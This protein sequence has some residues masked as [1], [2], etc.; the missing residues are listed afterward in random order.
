MAFILNFG[1]EN[2]RVFNDKTSIPLAP[3]T[4]LTGKNNSGKSSVI[5]AILMLQDSFKNPETTIDSHLDPILNILR[6]VSGNYFLSSFNKLLPHGQINNESI[7]ISFSLFIRGFPYLFNVTL[8]FTKRP[9]SFQNSNEG[10]LTGIRISLKSELVIEFVWAGSESRV[11]F[12]GI[13][14]RVNKKLTTKGDN[15]LKINPLFFDKLFSVNFDKYKKTLQYSINSANRLYIREAIQDYKKDP[16]RSY[17][18]SPSGFKAFEQNIGNWMDI[19]LWD[20]ESFCKIQ[21]SWLKMR[22]EENQLVNFLSEGIK[23]NSLDAISFVDCLSRLQSITMDLEDKVP[24]I[25]F[26]K[27]ILI[28]PFITALSKFGRSLDGFSYYS[29]NNSHLTGNFSKNNPSGFSQIIKDLD[30]NKLNKIEQNF[31]KEAF[32]LF[33]IADGVE[34]RKM[35]DLVSDVIFKKNSQEYTF[36]DMGFGSHQLIQ[37][38]FTVIHCSRKKMYSSFGVLNVYSP[39]LF[40]M[41]EPECNLHPD[42]QSKLADFFI[43]AI[44]TFNIQFII[45]T[46]SEY[47]IRKLQY[48]TANKEHNFNIK[49]E[50]TAVYYFND[51]KTLKK[52]EKQ[53]H[54]IKIREDGVL[55]GSFGPGFFDE[56]SNL[57]KEIF[58]LSG[59]N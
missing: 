32:R 23:Y 2:F 9:D 37:L 45:E 27:N 58:K 42:Y 19:E 30:N 38:I 12:R 51:P 54:H 16:S 34:I 40:I 8:S 33:D 3:L 17:V 22:A 59:A 48:L 43:L 41:E 49:P 4:I 56:A 7:N 14:S 5:K 18:A 10:H 1:I 25:A 53:V 36:F 20:E 15:Y 55:D 57:I 47:L 6:S 50:D 29:F 39:N 35:S 11:D 52:G 21:D 28:D 13:P 24:E 44:K 31:I 46:H 26:L